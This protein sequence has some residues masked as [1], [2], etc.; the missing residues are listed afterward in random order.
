MEKPAVIPIWA[1]PIPTEITTNHC[2]EVLGPGVGLNANKGLGRR[3]HVGKDNGWSSAL[4]TPIINGD[5]KKET[6]H[7][8]VE[9]IKLERAQSVEI[10][11]PRLGLAT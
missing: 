4:N 8:S 7:D 5:T 3:G 6:S 11:G 10:R 9:L 2:G 1:S